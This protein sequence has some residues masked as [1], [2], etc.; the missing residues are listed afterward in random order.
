MKLSMIRIFLTLV[1]LTTSLSVNSQNVRIYGTILENTDYSTVILS[2]AVFSK[3]LDSKIETSPK[4][5]AFEFNISVSNACFYK[6]YYKTK[7]IQLFVKPGANIQLTIDNTK[8]TNYTIFY[9]DLIQENT[10]LNLEST[11]Y[12]GN[13][14]DRENFKQA[15]QQGLEVYSKEIDNAYRLRSAKWDALVEEVSLSQEFVELYPRNYIEMASYLYKYY[16]PK[17]HGLNQDSFIAVHANF[18]DLYKSMPNHSDYYHCPLYIDNRMNILKANVNG[19]N[20]PLIISKNTDDLEL[21]KGYISEAE[22]EHDSYLRETLIENLIG[23][24]VNSYG[25]TSELK[26]EIVA[27]IDQVKDAD[28]KI[29]LKKRLVNLA[30][31]ETGQP[32]P[33]FSFEDYSGNKRHSRELVGKIVYI[34]VWSSTNT[35]SMTEWKAAKEIYIKYKDQPD[36]IFLYLSI[37]EGKETWEKA[38]REQKLTDEIQAISFPNG[39]NSD[40]ARKYAIQSLPS[41]ILIDKSGNIISNRVPKPSQPEKLIPLLDKLLGR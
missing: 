16:Y 24:W 39:Y 10:L 11:P 9:E 13:K 41:Y 31:Y 2:P 37:D 25:R 7:R 33:N 19:K 4:K 15:S 29:A 5:G 6:L 35:A 34:H 14:E 8:T 21:Y 36:F 28:R 18:L 12:L 40:F 20:K 30:Q 38:I 1:I 26:Q 23:E 22:L 17:Y 3:L 27:Y 32:A